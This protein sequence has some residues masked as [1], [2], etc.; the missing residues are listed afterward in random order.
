MDEGAMTKQF[1]VEVR[2]KQVLC[3]L[4]A[5]GTISRSTCSEAGDDGPGAELIERSRERH[6]LA[7]L[8]RWTP[9]QYPSA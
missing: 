5:A 4:L 2:G 6:E 7:G 1:M 8:L 9:A 3:S